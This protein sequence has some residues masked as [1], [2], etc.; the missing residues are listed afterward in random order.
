MAKKASGE[1]HDGIVKL[2]KT[3]MAGV[4]S[5]YLLTGSLVVTALGTATA[6][7]VVHLR[8][9]RDSGPS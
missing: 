5:L 3:S 9:F 2:I 6:V 1:Q 4:G 8:G 7:A